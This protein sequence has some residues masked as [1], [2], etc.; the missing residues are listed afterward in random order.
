[1]LPRIKRHVA[2]FKISVRKMEFWEQIEEQ[3]NESRFLAWLLVLS[4]I[5][6]VLWTSFNPQSPGV[7]IGL[8]ALVAGI[9]S[10]RPKMHSAEKFAWVAVLITFAV[11]EVHA[12]SRSDKENKQARDL[13]NQE[14]KSIANGLTDAI[15]A[16]QRHFDATMA[17]ES[18]IKNENY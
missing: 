8:L 4:A 16:D 18:E 3:W 6:L 17:R 2:R 12:I 11:L 9:M 10:V 15:G 7:S 1:M 13:Q 14:F 5:G